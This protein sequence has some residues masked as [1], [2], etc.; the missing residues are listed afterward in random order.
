MTRLRTLAAAL[1]AAALAACA[2]DAAP[3]DRDAA[4]G[5]FAAV[6]DDEV[7]PV[8]EGRTTWTT[9]WDLTWEEVGGADG[10]VV[11][12]GTPEGDST[13]TR[14]LDEPRLRLSVATGTTTPEDRALRRGQELTLTAAQL[15][16]RVAAHFPDGTLGPPS[17]WLLVGEPIARPG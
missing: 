6:L 14:E 16:V 8:T 10:Y 1:T 12:Y 15:S 3:P 4:P 5:G 7:G 17:P 9:F 13:R 11:W 2:A